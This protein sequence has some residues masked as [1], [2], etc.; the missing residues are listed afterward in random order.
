MKVSTQIERRRLFGMVSRFGLPEDWFRSDLGHRRFSLDKKA[1]KRGVKL[2]WESH[3]EF[4]AEPDYEWIIKESITDVQDPAQQLQG[5]TTQTTP[6]TDRD[7]I[8]IIA[9]FVQTLPYQ[10][11]STWRTLPNGDRLCRFGIA[12]PIEVLFL[13]WGDCDSKSLLFASILATFPGRSVV[14]IYG[15]GH[16]FAGVQTATRKGDHYVTVQGVP[17]VLVELTTPWPVGRIPRELYTQTKT[18]LY[19]IIPVVPLST[20]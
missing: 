11:P 7:L 5:I 19:E 18:G 3:W 1:A 20:S 14:F 17:H 13:K 8:R 6:G 2:T 15:D 12:P 16:L 10:I 4:T 9:S